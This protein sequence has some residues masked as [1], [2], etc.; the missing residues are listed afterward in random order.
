MLQTEL[1]EA[2]PA[3]HRYALALTRNSADADDLTQDTV[4]RALE[5]ADGY[6]SGTSI[7]PW[8]KTI[9]FRIFTDGVRVKQA[10]RRLAVYTAPVHA[11]INA[12]QEDA[13]ACREMYDAINRLSAVWGAAL[14]RMDVEGYTYPEAAQ[15]TGRS[16]SSAFRGIAVAR[17]ELKRAMRGAT[18]D[19][20]ERVVEQRRR[21]PTGPRAD[22]AAIENVFAAQRHRWPDPSLVPLARQ[23][24]EL[25]RV[26][27]IGY[28]AETIRKILNGT[29]VPLTSLGL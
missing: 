17:E 3:V 15:S 25:A 7:R 28:R 27:G 26:K 21:P 8:L 13:V 22:K 4:V 16:R 11:Y 9:M 12:S 2:L 20:D 29:Y 14:W 6:Q 1:I 19:G 24:R 5:H 23:A 10:D 18:Y